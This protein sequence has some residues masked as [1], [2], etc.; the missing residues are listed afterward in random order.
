MPTELTDLRAKLRSKTRE[1]LTLVA[2]SYGL[3][4]IN[5]LEPSRLERLN[6]KVEEIIVQ[7]EEALLEGD[8]PEAWRALDQRLTRT[9]IGRLLRERHAIRELILNLRDDDDEDFD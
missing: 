5:A 7:H 3:G 8:S 4:D 9:E 6:E 2:N 1:I